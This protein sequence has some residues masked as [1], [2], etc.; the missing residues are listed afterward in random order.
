MEKSLY[1]DS[2]EDPFLCGEGM[3]ANFLLHAVGVQ[4]P[5]EKNERSLRAPRLR[6][7]HHVALKPRRMYLT[8]TLSVQ[9]TLLRI[10]ER[11]PA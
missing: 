3:N 9:Q 2:V 10:F 6:D 5:T 4:T 8:L 1:L 7:Q 11:R